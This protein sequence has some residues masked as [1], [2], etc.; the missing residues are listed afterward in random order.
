MANHKAEKTFQCPVCKQPKPASLAMHGDILQHGVAEL[1]VAKNSDWSTTDPICLDCVNQHRADYIE[2]MLEKDKGELS[3]LE[4]EVVNSFKEHE[5]LAENLNQ[6]FERD[7]ILSE[8]IADKLATTV[9]SWSFIIGFGVFLL[10]WMAINTVLIIRHEFDPY[11]FILLNLVLSCLAAIQAPVIM[12][13]QKRQESRDRLRADQDYQINLKAELQI[14]H[15]NARMDQLITHQWRRLLEIQ[16]IQTQ[17][18]QELVA[19]RPRPK[20]G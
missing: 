3:S 15:L 10:V 12:M 1:V 13:S 18:M 7:L 17:L 14:R 16:K 19:S 9:G 5:L 4:D 8:R 20:G 6:Q 11:P 2:D